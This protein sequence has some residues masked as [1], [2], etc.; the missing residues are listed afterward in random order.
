MRKEGKPLAIASVELDREYVVHGIRLIRRTDGKLQIIYPML[1]SRI[2]VKGKRQVLAFKPL[3]REA[4]KRVE[5]AVI[6][7][8]RQET[9]IE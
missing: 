4:H 6:R 2:H 1:P 9:E 3:S 8:Y 5:E 7:R